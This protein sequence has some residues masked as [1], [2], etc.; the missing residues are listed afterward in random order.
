[1]LVFLLDFNRDL[2]YRDCFIELAVSRFGLQHECIQTALSLSPSFLSLWSELSEVEIIRARSRVV[3]T[4]VQAEVQR[5]VIEISGV[6]STKVSAFSSQRVSAQ[7][8]LILCIEREA[9]RG[10]FEQGEPDLHFIRVM[11]Q[12]SRWMF[13]QQWSIA[14]FLSL[15]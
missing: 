1:M 6:S 7:M 4:I 13:T 10:I 11:L 8:R 5:K 14:V 3:S 2:S 9:I 15:L 12:Q